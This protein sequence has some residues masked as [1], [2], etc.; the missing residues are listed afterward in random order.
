VTSASTAGATAGAAFSYQITASNAPI[1]FNV[2][3]LPTG[4]SVNTATGVISGSVATAGSYP[5]TISVNNATGTGATATLTISVINP[6][7]YARLVNLSA[8]AFVNTGSNILIAGFGIG[9]SGSKQLLLRG[10]G[11]RLALDPFDISGA[12]ANAQLGLYDSG[13][14]P[15]PAP[16]LIASDNGWAN[17][18]VAGNS[19]VSAVVGDTTAAIMST[20]GAFPYV[21]GSLD[22]AVDA[23]LT[24]GNYSSEISGLGGNPTGVALAEIYDADTGIPS[25]RLVNI[26]ARALVGTSSNILIAGFGIA[27]NTSETV[28]IRGIGP[29]LGLSPFYLSGVLATPQLTLYDGNTPSEIIAANSGW[30]TAPSTGPS[31]VVAVVQAASASV[32]SS[33]GAFALTSGSND[34]AMLVTLPP[35]N[36]T[37]QLSGVGGTTGIGLIEVYEAP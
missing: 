23:T 14:S 12:L 6:S 32:M 15:E 1:S 33:V 30:S 9:G 20:L 29:R 10:V 11:P 25:A 28:L 2:T 5:V 31:T 22:S 8:R 26:S 36:Y 27:G 4:L 37:A 7:S 21:S 24:T 34:A 16:E 13:A 35:G 17:A 18:T 19:P 3:G